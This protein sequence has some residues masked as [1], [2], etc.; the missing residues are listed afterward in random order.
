VEAAIVSGTG[1]TFGYRFTFSLPDGSAATCA[2]RFRAVS[3]SDG[4]S[5]ERAP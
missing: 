1:I 3:C 2:I 4:W 5:A